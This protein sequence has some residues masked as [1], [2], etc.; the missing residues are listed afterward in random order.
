MRAEFQEIEGGNLIIEFQLGD[1][2]EPTPHPAHLASV[3]DDA[4]STIEVL[5]SWKE[6]TAPEPTSRH[7][8]TCSGW[9]TNPCPTS[10]VALC[11][12]IFRRPSGT[13][14]TPPGISLCRPSAGAKRLSECRTGAGI[15]TDSQH[16]MLHAQVRLGVVARRASPRI[17]HL[18]RC[19]CRHA[20]W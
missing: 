19:R 6:S 12:M 13:A 7:C 10:P 17:S 4:V 5:S 8:R 9:A 2:A 20:R 14:L 1:E 11:M 3:I 15:A 18:T 16:T